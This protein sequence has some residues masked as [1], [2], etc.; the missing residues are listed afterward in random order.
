M[1]SAR[2]KGTDGGP[3]ARIASRAVDRVAGGP[4][5]TEPEWRSTVAVRED[6]DLAALLTARLPPEGAPRAISVTDLV[7]PRRAYWR[8]ISPVPASAEREERFDL[9]R[10]AHR[11]LGVALA[12]EGALEVRVRR[13]GFVGRIDLLADVPV[14]VKTSASPVVPSDLV[15]SRPEPVEQLGMYAALID[16]SIGRLLTVPVVDE[17]SSSVRAVDIEFRAPRATRDEMGRRAGALRQAWRTREPGPLPR[18]RWF[19]RGCEFQDEGVCGC[20]GDEPDAAEPTG[21][22]VTGV[23]DRPEI[24]AHIASRLEAVPAG[25]RATVRRFRDLLYPRRAYFE[26]TGEPAPPASFHADPSSAVDLYDRLRSALESGPLGEVARL[27]PR[28]DEP[29]EEV[30]GF[31]G[32]PFLLR[33]SRSWTSPR[34]A[35]LLEDQPQYALELGFRCVATGTSSGWLVLGRERAATEAERV[36]VFEFRLEQPTVFARLWR[37]RIRR[38]RAALD[39]RDPGSLAAC[40]RWMFDSCPYAAECGCGTEAAASQR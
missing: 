38:L 6:P 21:T 9:G 33:A 23:T 13:D 30:G 27:P 40:P 11:R 32:A 16:R 2:K 19:G 39:T 36:R 4:E 5:S 14:E 34:A 12:G 7:S 37:D 24:A 1:R 18:C 25:A 31:R 10:A 26:R 3:R 17:R 28:T 35:G 15:T 8:A 22:F 29:D 20:T